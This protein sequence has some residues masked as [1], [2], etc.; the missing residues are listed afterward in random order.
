LSNLSDNKYS[1]DIHEQQNENKSMECSLEQPQS[2]NNLMYPRLLPVTPTIEA[3]PDV[4]TISQPVKE[5]PLN[6]LSSMH[7][8]YNDDEN[9]QLRLKEE[10]QIQMKII[11]SM[12]HIKDKM[13]NKNFNQQ[14]QQNQQHTDKDISNSNG[15]KLNVRSINEMNEQNNIKELEKEKVK[16]TEFNKIRPM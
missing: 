2:Q 12:Q 1:V 4:E 9:V 8:K 11:N 14:N 5:H 7:N 13:I 10:Q 15:Q 6:D 16:E 3:A